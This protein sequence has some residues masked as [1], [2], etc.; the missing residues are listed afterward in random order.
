MEIQKRHILNNWKRDTFDPRDLYHLPMAPA[1][2][3]P[4]KVDLRSLCSPVEDQGQLGSCTGNAIVGALEF[5]ENKENAGAGHGDPFNNLSRLFVYYNERVIEHDVGQDNGAQIRDG[6]KSIAK[7][8]VC[9]EVTWPYDIAKFKDKPPGAAY[10]E[11]TGRRIT[12]YKRVAQT[13]IDIMGTLA[14][15][16]PIV[17]GFNVYSDFESSEVAST[18]VVNLPTAKEQP[19]GGHAVLMV[20][21]D[22][23]AARV[24][25]RNS[26]GAGW[27]QA[28]YFTMPFAYVINPKL[29][30]D[31][32]V[33]QK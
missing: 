7:Q 28:G 22:E 1:R 19:V 11:A 18:G 16:D 33:V 26:W 17:F 25:V 30:D 8:G 24:I 3:Y 4:P 5:L 12:Q 20:G 23:A 15:G 13:E 14:G 31:L 2:A 21:Y 32:W 9:S 10:A 27:G 6:I 29:A